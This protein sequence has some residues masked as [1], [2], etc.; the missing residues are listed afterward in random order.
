MKLP[1]ATTRRSRADIGAAAVDFVL[2]SVVV[3]PL[4]LGVLQVGLFL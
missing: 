1:A 3:V 4:F 2:V